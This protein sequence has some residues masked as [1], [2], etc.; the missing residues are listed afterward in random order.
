MVYEATDRRALASKAASWGRCAL[1]LFQ[2]EEL[3]ED[4][5]TVQMI[6]EE[7]EVL[8]SLPR[9]PAVVQLLQVVS[10]PDVV[11]LA[12]ELVAGGDL[13]S[14]IE[15]S[16]P[17][18]EG[19][20]R[21]LFLQ[22]CSRVPH[23]LAVVPTQPPPTLCAA[24]QI[25]DGL[26]HLHSH[27]IAHRDL[28]PENICFADSSQRSLKLIDLGAAAFITPA[29]FS[30][31][32][33]T[34]LYAAPEICPWFFQEND[35]ASSPGLRSG[36]SWGSLDD[37]EDDACP[38]LAGDHSNGMWSAPR[39][40]GD[41]MPAPYGPAVD[42]WAA[43]AL[44]Y[45]MLSGEAPFDQ[46][47]EVEDLLIDIAAMTPRSVPMESE[48]WSRVSDSAKDLVHCL[49]EPSPILRYNGHRARE[50]RWLAPFAVAIAPAIPSRDPL[51]PAQRS[52]AG[53]LSQHSP[54]A[55]AGA[56]VAAAAPAPDDS[57][58]ALAFSYLPHAFSAEQAAGLQGDLRILILPEPTA[59]GRVVA[60]TVRLTP[61][62]AEVIAGRAAEA[63]AATA[64]IARSSLLRW[65]AG[66]APFLHAAPLPA[67]SLAPRFIAT[68]TPDRRQYKAY[69]AAG[70]DRE[71][72]AKEGGRMSRGSAPFLGR[73]LSFSMRKAKSAE[74][75]A[76][77]QTPSKLPPLDR[78]SSPEGVDTTALWHAQSADKQQL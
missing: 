67:D 27:G 77:M 53:A 26:E 52:Q 76:N 11:A 25:L 61:C 59:I 75:L 66:E 29:G 56:A 58:L 33:G 71:R 46:E 28:K 22:V 73:V 35:C 24:F 57:D 69:I 20:A 54:A 72:A 49:I 7:V 41:S 62:T 6:K 38:P 39:S 45:V 16:G 43:G 50:H 5:G 32:A 51:R 65:A 60:Y 68:F 31:L 23:A 19:R 3:R 63:P 64:A 47:K 34:P 44:L 21:G 40:P 12:L 78:R 70:S 74:N 37:D 15:A 8:L 14:M 42:F 48:V 36:M 18:P 55:F 30:D 2:T 17:C 13:F 10:T 1:K 4:D 9:H